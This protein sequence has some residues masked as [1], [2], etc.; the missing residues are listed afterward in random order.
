MD[1]VQ[2]R[3]IQPFAMY[4]FEFSHNL[5][6]QD[7]S[8]IW[9]NLPPDIGLS[10]EESE[11]SITHELLAKELI[12]GG[13]QVD[14]GIIDD[15][16]LGNEMPTDIQW[17]I[18]KVKQKAKTKYFSKVIKKTSEVAKTKKQ[19]AEDKKQQ[20]KGVNPEITYNWPYDFFSLV[21]LVKLDAEVTF[22]DIETDQNGSTKIKSKQKNPDLKSKQ[23]IPNSITEALGKKGVS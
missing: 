18:F 13:A 8:H 4:I 19:L 2:Y 15:E 3:D 6:K 23:A 7:L 10:F 17:M 1:F 9:Q 20:A 11:S 14:S 21:E 5:S 16:A 12:G 22:S